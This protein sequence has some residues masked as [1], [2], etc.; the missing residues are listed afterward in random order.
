MISVDPH[1]DIGSVREL[2]M[3]KD[4]KD[5]VINKMT[6]VAGGYGCYI[7]LLFDDN[8]VKTINIRAPDLELR[9]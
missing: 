2:D 5:L 7:A 8:T 9:I 1:N 6:K 3:P 4:I